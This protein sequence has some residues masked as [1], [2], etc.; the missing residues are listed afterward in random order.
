MFGS[1]RGPSG[2]RCPEIT[3]EASRDSA[4][5]NLSIFLAVDWPPCPTTGRA[6][7]ATCQSS[8]TTFSFS[9]SP[10]FG[11]FPAC[12]THVRLA[13]KLACYSHIGGRTDPMV[14]QFRAAGA[15]EASEG[16]SANASRSSPVLLDLFRA[17]VL[18]PM[19]LIFSFK[20]PATV[21]SPAL[22]HLSSCD[23]MKSYAARRSVLANTDHEWLSSNI[24]WCLHEYCFDLSCTAKPD[25][26]KERSCVAESSHKIATLLSSLGR[27]WRHFAPA[28]LCRAIPCE[29]VPRQTAP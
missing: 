7:T 23:C 6:M 20:H 17:T 14:T 26:L 9:F 24:S 29:A 25:D 2:T 12:A 3:E 21:C 19:N 4:A 27:R 28:S 16:E 1:R 15:I 8:A 5:P 22:A 11:T 13:S 18:Y 10:G